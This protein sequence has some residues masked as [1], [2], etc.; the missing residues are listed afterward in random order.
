MW[1]NLTLNNQINKTIQP[2]VFYGSSNGTGAKLLGWR[3]FQDNIQRFDKDGYLEITAE[4]NMSQQKPQKLKITEY[5]MVPW[6]GFKLDAQN[7]LQNKAM[8]S[9]IFDK[10]DDSWFTLILA[11]MI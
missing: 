6:H 4:M 5:C 9:K 3:T 8:K 10:F 7:I 1:V 2:D 11:T